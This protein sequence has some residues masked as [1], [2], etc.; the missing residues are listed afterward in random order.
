MVQ[1]HIPKIK[2]TPRRFVFDFIGFLHHFDFIINSYCVSMHNFSGRQMSLFYFIS[3][4]TKS[5]SY[6]IPNTMIDQFDVAK[7]KTFEQQICKQNSKS[8]DKLN[9]ISLMLIE[10]KLVNR[11][12][13]CVMR[14]AITKHRW[15]SKVFG[16]LYIVKWNHCSLIRF[17]IRTFVV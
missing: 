15:C 17:E 10:P 7:G 1:P 2:F 9:F 3:T 12:T 5:G 11:W 13:K 6:S 4:Q 16:Q 14:K 8:M